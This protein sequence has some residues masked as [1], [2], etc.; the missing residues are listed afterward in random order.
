MFCSSNQSWCLCTDGGNVYQGA[1]ST[2]KESEAVA[3]SSAHPSEESR[4]CSIAARAPRQA[5]QGL[6]V[7][8][9]P[10][11]LQDRLQHPTF[12]H[13]QRGTCSQK[14]STQRWWEDT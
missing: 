10:T 5:V 2:V 12:L 13:E 11:W 7:G 1:G 3:K 4:V 6:P 14:R 8:W 9:H